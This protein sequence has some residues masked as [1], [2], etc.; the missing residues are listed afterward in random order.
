[1]GIDQPY[2]LFDRFYERPTWLATGVRRDGSSVD[3]I[4]IVA[5]GLVP[6]RDWLA[7]IW[8]KAAFNLHAAEGPSLAHFFCH[9]YSRDRGEP[10]SAVRVVLSS[11]LQS[12]PGAALNPL[13]TRVYHDGPCP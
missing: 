1:M 12:L 9:G 6:N 11:R 4:P 5:P 7:D 13:V 8:V 3:L 10:L 2:A